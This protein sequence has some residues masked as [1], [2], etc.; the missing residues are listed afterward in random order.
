MMIFLLLT[1]EIDERLDHFVKREFLAKGKSIIAVGA[2]VAENH[3]D[4]VFYRLW[5]VIF[6]EYAR[7]SL[8]DENESLNPRGN[9][10]HTD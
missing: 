1:Y 9:H 7:L 5:L 10:R 3:I 6:K 8:L 2:I 4:S